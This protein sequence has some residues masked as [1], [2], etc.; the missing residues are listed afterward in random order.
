MRCDGTNLGYQDLR[1]ETSRK[2]FC[3][4]GD[5][6]LRL[7][8]P[9]SQYLLFM[10][11]VFGQ[12]FLRESNAMAFGWGDEGLA[13]EDE[14]MQDAAAAS[15]DLAVWQPVPKYLDWSF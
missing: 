15:F 6:T 7:I 14:Q 10:L 11:V 13:W 9:L 8:G 12:L 2:P 1:R 4:D 5:L 3:H